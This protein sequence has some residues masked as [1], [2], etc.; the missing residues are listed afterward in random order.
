MS[1]GALE[2]AARA[3][4][5]R[6][7]AAF[8]AQR[9]R[10]PLLGPILFALGAAAWLSG[11]VRPPAL[12][13]AQFAAASL[14]IGLLA[15][16]AAGRVVRPRMDSSRLALAALAAGLA[17]AFVGAAVAAHRMDVRAAPR[18]AAPIG[19]VLVRGWVAAVEP[20]RRQPRFLIREVAVDGGPRLRFARVAAADGPGPGRGIE[21]LAMLAPPPPPLAPGAFDSQRR[22]YVEQVGATGFALGRCRPVEAPPLTRF[23]DRAAMLVAAVR[24]DVTEAII[25][26]AAGRGGAIT[27]ALITGDASF[28][29]AEALD[30]LRDSGLGHLLS[31]SGLHMGLVAGMTFGAVTMLAALI[32]GLALR[33]P[34][35]KIGA[36]AAI[37]AGGAYLVLSGSSVPAERAY[38]MTVVAFGAILLDRPAFTMRALALALVVVLAAR[39]ESVL[40][41][42]F[43]MS[44]AA[45][46]AL[47]ALYEGHRARAGPAPG[48]GG[49]VRALMWL[50]AAVTADLAVALVAGAATDPFVLYHFGRF[51][52]YSAAANLA[53]GPIVALVVA[54]AAALAAVVAPLGLAET[55]LSIAS[56]GLDLVVQI[57]ALFASRSEAVV[58]VPAIPTAAFLLAVAA[59]CWAFV[60]RG[61][62]RALALAPALAA[63]GLAFSVER[64]IIWARDDAKVALARVALD[65]GQV[66]WRS[67]APARGGGFARD[68]L[69]SRAGI[70]PEEAL[71]LPAPD[72]CAP[73]VACQWRTPAGLDVAWAPDAD[74]LARACAVADLILSPISADVAPAQCR[75]KLLAPTSDG[76]GGWAVYDGARPRFVRARAERDL[77]APWARP[78][79]ATDSGE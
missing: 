46:G 19:P 32:P 78:T 36:L 70:K 48:G 15:L 21:C 77:D 47:I 27:A 54:P 53:A 58:A 7:G 45:T 49:V 63:L 67:L 20:G 42:G 59:L 68:R 40:E 71:D 14:A 52:P 50:Q 56:W 38:L 24:R 44:F 6:L 28:V 69:A 73:D 33:A 35:R 25:D 65:D 31:V 60:W 13:L 64:P 4:A 8:A 18:L 39:P 55:P 57:G 1:A 75:A 22:A 61:A 23:A 29:D 3:F 66:V 2:S 72:G 76:R 74:A 51:T 11:P 16:F 41:P 26:M 12:M 37:G 62:V 17:F 30:A 79:A 10:L 9:D 43:Q 34:V 5:L